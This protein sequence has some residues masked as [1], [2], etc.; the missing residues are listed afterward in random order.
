MSPPTGDQGSCTRHMKHLKQIH[1]SAGH[2]W[3]ILIRFQY[4]YS[5]CLS[6]SS[7]ALSNW[8]YLVTLGSYAG[9][10]PESISDD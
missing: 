2:Y 10:T 3:L 1:F 4:L 6:I 5:Y 9:W 7:P 8:N